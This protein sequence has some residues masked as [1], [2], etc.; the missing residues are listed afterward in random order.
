MQK[1]VIVLVLSVENKQ[2]NGQMAGLLVFVMNAMKKLRVGENNVEDL[3][4]KI[5]TRLTVIGLDENYEKIRKDSNRKWICEC[6]CGK[7][8]S[9]FGSSLRS[10]AT[11]SCGC[12]NKERT[13][14]RNHNK[15]KSFIG[16]TYG[17][18]T[19]IEII[20]KNNRSL[21]RCVCECG[22]EVIVQKDHLKTGHTKSCGCLQKETMQRIRFV[23]ETGHKYG[24]LTVL[25]QY[26]WM[27]KKREAL[28]L[29]QCECG[30]TTVVQGGNLRTGNTKSC[31]CELSRGEVSVEKLLKDNNIPYTK[32]Y[33]FEDLLSEKGN[34][35]RFD[36]CIFNNGAPYYFIECDGLQHYQYGTFDYTDEET[37]LLWERDKKKEQYLFEHGY[38]LIRIPYEHYND[39]SLEDIGIRSKYIKQY[40]IN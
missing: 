34:H 30:N 1:L 21:C 37:E 19:V 7:T 24:K 39:I 23:D 28:W 15:S 27:N 22:N 25:Q 17:R 2:L 5:F 33:K 32:E 13:I 18:L 10:G 3:T 31:G 12:L 38:P 36:F 4:G 26:G 35:L 16:N 40:K 29:C 20:L 11:K 6:E 8:K 9:I 14:Q